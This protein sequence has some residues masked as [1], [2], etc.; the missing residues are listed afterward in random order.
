MNAKASI[1]EIKALFP[2]QHRKIEEA[3]AKKGITTADIQWEYDWCV[4]IGNPNMNCSDWKSMPVPKDPETLQEFEDEIKDRYGV[5]LIGKSGRKR[6][7]ERVDIKQSM[8]KMFK[9][10]AA[11]NHQE[12]TKRTNKDSAK[13]SNLDS[14]LK[15]VGKSGSYAPIKTPS[16]GGIFGMIASNIASQSIV[17]PTLDDIRS[18][19]PDIAQKYEAMADGTKLII[20]NPQGSDTDE[21][22]F[23]TRDIKLATRRDKETRVIVD[24]TGLSGSNYVI[25]GDTAKWN[26]N[27]RGI[28]KAI[29]APEGSEFRGWKNTKQYRYTRDEIKAITGGK[30]Y[31][32]GF[33]F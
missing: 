14:V 11:S 2:D 24:E 32:F 27:L 21:W 20:F 26:G 29:A 25:F 4:R 10:I 12:Q 18:A 28:E 30:I 17:Y 5:S 22:G 9:D 23:S 33:Y 1:E 31:T 6:N 19:R 16:G 13:T 8:P 15:A 3:M 7:A